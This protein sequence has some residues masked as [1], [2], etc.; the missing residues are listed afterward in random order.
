MIEY[1]TRR[2]QIPIEREPLGV[3]GVRHTPKEDAGLLEGLP[4]EREA[5]PTHI[6]ELTRTL[7]QNHGW[8][9]IRYKCR[10]MRLT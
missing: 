5:L 7:S 3:A 9:S 8:V 2:L 6:K 10:M 1:V 4:V